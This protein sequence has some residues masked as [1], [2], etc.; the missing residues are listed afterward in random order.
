MNNNILQCEKIPYFEK[1]KIEFEK[2]NHFLFKIYKKF[3]GF[4]VLRS[5]EHKAT[6]TK[7]LSNSKVNNK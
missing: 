5:A 3:K 2:G 4:V 1:V 6:Q 7:K